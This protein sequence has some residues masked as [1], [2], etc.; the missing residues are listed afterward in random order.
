MALKPWPVM[1]LSDDPIR[2]LSQYLKDRYFLAA[3]EALPVAPEVWSTQPENRLRLSE[4]SLRLDAALQILSHPD[5]DYPFTRL[6]HAE[7]HGVHQP[8]RNVISR[9]L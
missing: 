8:G 7:V 5:K 9:S 1:R 2:T 6:R 4:P 3:K